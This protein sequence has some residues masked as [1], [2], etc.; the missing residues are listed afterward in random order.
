MQVNWKDTS[1]AADS[2]RKLWYDRNSSTADRCMSLRTG[3]IHKPY[4]PTNCFT[5]KMLPIF[6]ASV[7]RRPGF[8]AHAKYVGLHRKVVA[9]KFSTRMARFYP[10]TRSFPSRWT[11][12]SRAGTIHD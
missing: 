5:D 7:S 10:P 9:L 2:S 4:R 12:N 11:G 1:K 3:P 8:A 6:L